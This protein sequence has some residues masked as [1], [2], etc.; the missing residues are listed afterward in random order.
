MA[1]DLGE[2]KLWIQNSSRPAGMYSAGCKISNDD[3]DVSLRRNGD[4]I[5]HK[6]MTTLNKQILVHVIIGPIFEFFFW[7]NL[8]FQTMWGLS[9]W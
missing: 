2:G 9:F 3:D 4:Y 8:L 6:F 1:T 7:S 5:N